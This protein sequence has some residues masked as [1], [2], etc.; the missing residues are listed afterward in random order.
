MKCSAARDLIFRKIDN[1]LSGPE[2]LILNDHLEHCPTCAREYRLLSLPRRLAQNLVPFD[3]S[4]YFHQKLTARIQSENQ[5]AAIFQLFFGLARR[6]VPSMAA[7][8]LVLLSVFAYFQLNRPQD[9]L[10]TAYEKMLTGEDLP[11]HLM[12][13]EQRNITDESI[14]GAIA[15]RGIWQD[16]DLRQK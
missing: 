13:T 6:I 16:T 2:N 4:P 14:L 5:N 8:T 3:T 15:T 7:L 1:E 9:N 12:V 10:Y 11:L